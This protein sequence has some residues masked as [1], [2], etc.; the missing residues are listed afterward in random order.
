MNDTDL[1]NKIAF[2]A[3]AEKVIEDKTKEGIFY[4]KSLSNVNGKRSSRS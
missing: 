3:V 1:L 2:D 4:F